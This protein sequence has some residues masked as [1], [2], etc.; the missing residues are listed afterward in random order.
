MQR[1]RALACDDV[2]G[3]GDDRGLARLDDAEADL[4]GPRVGA[5]LGDG[6]PRQEAELLGDRGEEPADRGAQVDDSVGDLVEDV[7]APDVLVELDGP[8]ALVAVVVH[9]Q[10]GGVDVDGPLARE[11]VGEPVGGV[12]EA[13]GALVAVGLVRAQPGGFEGVPFGGRGHRAAAVVIAGPVLDRLGARALL[14]GAHV[15]PHDGVAELVAVL[16]DGDHGH[17]RRVVGDAGDVARGDAGLV[18]DALDRGH[19]GVPPVLGALLRPS[20]LGVVGL[21]GGGGEGYRVPPQVE[22]GGP[23]RLRAVVDAEQEWSFVSGCDH[24]V[25]P[26]MGSCGAVTSV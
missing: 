9:A 7:P 2:G 22:D 15:H 20:G 25:L 19:Q 23:A 17:G 24:C 5:A 6:R 1:G 3:S 18:H 14:C 12:D 13:V 11:L 4:A 10:R 21:V 26:S 16:V 8:S